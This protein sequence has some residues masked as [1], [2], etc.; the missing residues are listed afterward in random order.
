MIREKCG[1]CNSKNINIFYEI[2]NIPIKLSCIKEYKN[3][4]E[5]MSFF[6]CKD[7]LTIQLDKLIPLDILY[8]DSHNYTS[9]GETWNNYFKLFCNN[10]KDLI[11]N[12]NVLEIGCP[13]GKIVKNSINYNKWYIVDPNKNENIV[14][15]NIIFLKQMFDEKFEINEKIDI[16]I[17][18]HLFEHIYEPNIFLNKCYDILDDN[19]EMFFGIPNMEYIAEKELCPFLG[20]FFEHTIFLNNDNVKYLLNNNGFDIIRIINYENHSTLFHVKKNILK[21]KN[22]NKIFKIDNKFIDMFY[23]TINKYSSFVKYCNEIIEINNKKNIYLFGASYNTQYL[24]A[25]G[26]NQQN[27][28]GILDNSKEKEGK[29]FYGYNLIIYNPS[30]LINDDC[31]VILKNGFYSNEIKKQILEINSKILILS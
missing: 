16:I 18:S 26:I 3:D 6:K 8:S 5:T 23:N 14:F 9:Y 25:F 27:I 20:I 29:Y 1:I 10:I 15:N 28:K 4:L 2:K 12:K 19:G 30:I 17:H 13:S 7:C 24:I 11:F 21:N 22:E 31:I